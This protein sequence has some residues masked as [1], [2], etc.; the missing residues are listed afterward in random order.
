KT[1]WQPEFFVL[2]KKFSQV[3]QEYKG[4]CM[5]TET[6]TDL[7]GLIKTYAAAGWKYFQP[8]NFSLITLPW[9]AEVHKHYIDEYEKALGELYIPCWV[10]GNHDKPRIATRIGKKQA[11]I[12]A[13]LELTLRGFS[14]V[15]YGEE[16]GMV[17]SNVKKENVMD[18]YEIMSPGL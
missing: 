1:L 11:R 3:L 14:F 4:K 7:P 9:R 5:V 17:N 12:A 6:W 8:F 13:M 2:M 16:I 10:L 18:P 15:Y